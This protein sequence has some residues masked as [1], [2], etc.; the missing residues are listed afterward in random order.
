MENSNARENASRI[1]HEYK[2]E[3]LVMK[4]VP[5]R[6]AKLRRDRDDPYAV[7]HV[8]ANGTLQILKDVVAKRIGLTVLR[9]DGE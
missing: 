4:T 1:K 6:L 2:V 7:T 5:G 3:D 9:T 8:Y